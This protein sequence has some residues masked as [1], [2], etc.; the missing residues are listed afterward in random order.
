[1]ACSDRL[2]LLLR[3]ALLVSMSDLRAALSWTCIGLKRLLTISSRHLTGLQHLRNPMTIQ[4]TERVKRRA[5]PI[6]KAWKRHGKGMDKTSECME[7]AWKRHGQN[8]RVNHEECFGQSSL[9]WR[10][11]AFSPPGTSWPH[12]LQRHTPGSGGGSG[13]LGAAFDDVEPTSDA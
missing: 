6:E 3:S 12:F 5:N 8:L 7:K 11:A 9:A 13:A 4:S 1:M 2:V 10:L